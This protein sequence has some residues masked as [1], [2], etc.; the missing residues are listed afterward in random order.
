LQAILKSLDRQRLKRIV[1]EQILIAVIDNSETSTAAQVCNEYASHG[2]FALQCVVERKKGLS[3]AR[4]A[5]LA[6]AQGAGAAHIAVIDDDELPLPTWLDA[7]LD[8]IETTG[9]G[10]AIGPVVPLFEQPPPR[11]LPRLA[12]QDRRQPRSGYVDDGYTSN[13]ILDLSAIEAMGLRFD[14]QFNEIGGEDTIFF[15][16]MQDR[17]LRI[18]WSEQAVVHAIIPL[19]RMSARWI[20]RR[21][22]R[23]GS[24]E[25]HLGGFD[26]STPTGRLRNAGR[27]AVRLIGGGLRIAGSGILNGWWRPDAV[28]ASFFTACRGAGLIANALGFDYQ[29]YARTRYR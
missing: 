28:V 4:N 25:A 8:T 26:P 12:Y 14:V 17:G 5:A 18:A 15:K 23:T 10:A 22:Y 1:D 3:Y 13:A 29:E 7:L 2:R 6:V 27:G 19:H 20:W 9:A 11:T 16:Q 21:W 24:I